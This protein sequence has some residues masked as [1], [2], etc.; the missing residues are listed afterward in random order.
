MKKEIRM[1]CAG[2]MTVS[3]LAGCT[4]TQLNETQQNEEQEETQQEETTAE[5][6]VGGWK[7]NESYS[8]CLDDEEQKIF[9]KAIE[10]LTGA[11]Y[12]PIRVLATQIVS[13]KN[14]AYLCAYKNVSA[15]EDAGYCIVTVYNDLEDNAEIISIER[16]DVADVKTAD[17]KDT[18]GMTGAWEVKGTGK[19]GALSEEAENALSK[20]LEGFTGTGQIPILLLGTQLVSGM[21]YKILCIGETVTESPVR[22]VYV[23]TV[24]E[25]LEGNCELSDLSVFDLTAYIN[26]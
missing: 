12:D 18:S 17:Q 21:N 13:G 16:I 8:T 19:P 26:N 9:D 11:G 7:V 3:L 24:Y 6:V 1:I 10:G 14:Y 25:D 15:A 5:T 2:L 23:A 4:S 20:A 22:S